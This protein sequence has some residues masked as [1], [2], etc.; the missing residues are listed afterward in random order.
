MDTVL[1]RIY[2]PGLG[3]NHI[4][5]AKHTDASKMQET[6]V[7]I[8]SWMDGKVAILVILPSLTMQ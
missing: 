5:V 6:L 1:T 4:I 3:S 8:T 7:A 2:N